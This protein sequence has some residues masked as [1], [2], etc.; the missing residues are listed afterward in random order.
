M[1]HRYLR[2]MGLL[3]AGS[4]LGVGMAAAAYANTGEKRW[5]YVAD[6]KEDNIVCSF[7][8]LKLSLPEEWEGK[9][10]TETEE[11]SIAFYHK[12]SR[13]AG[14]KDG[15]VGCGY[16]FWLNYSEN[17]D[18]T[19]KG[20]GYYL[21]GSGENGVYYITVPHDLHG[22]QKD[23]RI[24]KEWQDMS[25]DIEWICKN[26]NAD[27]PG[28][29]MYTTTGVNLR[30]GKSTEDKVLD[31]ISSDS[32]VWVTGNMESGWVQVNH[33]DDK[34]Y[35]KR[36]YLEFRK[37]W[38]ADSVDSGENDTGSGKA[39]NLAEPGESPSRDNKDTDENNA[40]KDD[41]E[42]PPQG[43]FQAVMYGSDG[44][45]VLIKQASDGNWYDEAGVYYGT[46]D[47]IGDAMISGDS[48]TNSNGETFYWTLP[49]VEGEDPEIPPQGAFQA[50]MYNADGESVVIRPGDD[51][52]WYDESGVYYGSS[53]T[54]NDALSSGASITNANGETYY[55]SLPQ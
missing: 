11:D 9:Y 4:V 2:G 42:I 55:W 13:E 46:G 28:A 8:E 47:N 31:V 20:P 14:D 48:V 21:V 38:E 10:D 34:G 25:R 51:G 50:M 17:M 30:N 12:A 7:R 54:V 15:E 33:D 40:P 18:F 37:N 43:A 26:V 39:D 5:E 19:E 52:N 29:P 3:A 44:S 16:L 27:N 41:S 45:S 6:K 22:Y 24:L 1:K 23:A 53:D 35:I 36:D 32:L 49:E